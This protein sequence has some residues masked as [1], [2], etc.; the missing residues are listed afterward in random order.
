M[1][2]A[3]LQI[4]YA[5]TVTTSSGRKKLPVQDADTFQS[6]LFGTPERDKVL[7]E[8][9][10]TRPMSP[11]WKTWIRKDWWGREERENSIDPALYDLRDRLLS[12]AGEAVCMC[13]PEPDVQDILSYGQIWFG[14]NAKKVKGRMSQCHANA[15][16]LASRSNG[17]YR[18]CT[19]YA[20]SDDGMWRQH[21]W[22]VEIRP[23][24]V[25]VIETTEER[26]LYYGYVLTDEDVREFNR[27]LW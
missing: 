17:A 15:S 5:N 3:E 20:L 12:F 8:T 18:L 26:I 6:V 4:L 9:L 23:R 7:R 24:S 25:R 13:F 11:Q 2:R 1:D 22:C 21:S 16:L 10:K 14:R 19:G 27:R